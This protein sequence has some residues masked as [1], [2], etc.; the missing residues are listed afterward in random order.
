MY[1][2]CGIFV[3]TT[4]LVENTIIL[5]EVE[6]NNSPGN[7]EIRKEDILEKSRRLKQ[8]EGVEH[9]ELKGF[10]SGWLKTHIFILPL[11]LF[12]G[13]TGQTV[14]WLGIVSVTAGFDFG[15]QLEIYRFTKKK[16]HLVQSIF[17]ASCAILFAFF[18][19]AETQGWWG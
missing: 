15:H 2:A 13:F 9:A 18:A 10:R 3:L 1:L 5:G 17:F 7:N 4:I 6:M 14:A 12:F 16:S 8:D 11:I 19:I